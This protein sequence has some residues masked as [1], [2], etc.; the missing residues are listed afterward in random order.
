MSNIINTF[1]S[2]FNNI[3]NR[4]EDED[5]QIRSIIEPSLSDVGL[6]L[7]SLPNESNLPD[8]E[9]LDESLQCKI[10]HKNQSQRIIFPCK[11]KCLCY[12][13]VDHFIDNPFSNCPNCNKLIQSIY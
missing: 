10:C 8:Q 7:I 5:K 9:T 11:C 4:D 1:F 12:Y 13:C 6:T 3:K 2:L